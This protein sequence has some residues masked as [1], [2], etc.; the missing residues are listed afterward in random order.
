MKTITDHELS[1]IAEN[2][3]KEMPINTGIRTAFAAG[4]R[5]AEQEVKNCNTPTVSVPKG[6][7]CDVYF[8]QCEH[9]INNPHQR[10]YAC[11]KLY[12]KAAH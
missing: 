8:E 10:C 11:T 1:M 6:T 4:Y 9:W 5:L 3:A 2:W 7:A 12:K